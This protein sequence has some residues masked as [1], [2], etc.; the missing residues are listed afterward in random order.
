MPLQQVLYILWRRLWIVVLAFAS[1]LA[2]AVAVL[3]VVPARYDAVATASIDPGQA[4]PVSG[5]LI[6][7]TTMVGIMQGNLVALATSSQ[8]ALEVVKRLNLA[9]NAETIAGYDQSGSAGIV[10]IDQWVASGLLIH[11]DAKFGIGSNVLSITYKSSSP[12]QSALIANSFMSAFVDAAIAAK[13]AAAQQ[14]AQWFAPQIDKL[15]AELT[16]AHEKLA[17]FQAES[18]LLSPTGS[19]SENEQLLA[20]TNELDQAKAELVS[21]KSQLAGSPEAAAESNDAQSIDL[22]TLTTLRANLAAVNA[23]I[24][25]LQVEVG[26]GNPK[27]VERLSTRKSLLDQIETHIAEYKS[28]LQSRV[29]AQQGKISALEMARAD[30]MRRMIQVQG[31]RDEL[32]SLTREVAF[33]QD[34]VDRVAKAAVQARLQSQ[35]SFSNISLID[36]A[37]PPTS[38]SFPKPILVAIGGVGLGLALGLILA[39]LA[40][41]LDR[42]VRHASDLGFVASASVLGELARTS[43]TARRGRRPAWLRDRVGGNLPARSSSGAAEPN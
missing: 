4:D 2:G 18:N 1:T 9:S 17:H 14:A 15:R 29:T 24:G 21:L 41:A 38:V 3:I 42:R 39:L 25:K 40:E 37:S 33:S 32:A 5:E 36:K 13:G 23:E 10:D 22:S 27:L 19:D 43:R 6:G 12:S 30:Q 16:A 31:K 34:E 8:V 26:S 7:G 28:K 11:E 35:L 20:V